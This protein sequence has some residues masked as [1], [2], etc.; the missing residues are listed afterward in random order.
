[1]AA[2]RAADFHPL[3]GGMDDD[4]C[5]AAIDAFHNLFPIEALAKVFLCAL[6]V[7]AVKRFTAETQRA[8]RIL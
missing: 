3:S 6:R 8:Q 1:M 4:L 5:L 2:T 7:S